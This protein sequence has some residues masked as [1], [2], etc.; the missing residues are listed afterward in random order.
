MKEARAAGQRTKALDGAKTS[1]SKA[2]AVIK[3]KVDV[4]KTNRELF[5]RENLD[6]IEDTLL[7]ADEPSTE[8]AARLEEGTAEDAS[9]VDAE[10]SLL[11]ETATAENLMEE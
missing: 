2:N 11:E 4:Q 9:A 8:E 1:A 6:E 7:E 10:Y 3:P 5:C